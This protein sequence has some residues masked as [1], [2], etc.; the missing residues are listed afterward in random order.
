[1]KSRGQASSRR[2]RR[3]PAHTKKG[4]E[5]SALTYPGAGAETWYIGGGQALQD[6]GSQ[7]SSPGGHKPAAQDLRH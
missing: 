2:T 4:K 5:S 7:P 6:L 3:P 1:M